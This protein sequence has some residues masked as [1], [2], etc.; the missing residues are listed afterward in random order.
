MVS[1]CHFFCLRFKNIA[2]S[3][4][5]E[6]Y[7][8]QTYVHVDSRTHN[9]TTVSLYPAVS[10]N[11]ALRYLIF[12][13]HIRCLMKLTTFNVFSYIIFHSWAYSQIFLPSLVITFVK[14]HGWE[15][16]WSGSRRGGGNVQAGKS[17]SGKCPVLLKFVSE[18]LSK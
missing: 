14:T 15:N 4:R 5:E 6:I 11:H 1:F 9:K 18:T 16:I 10:F 2:S 8:L 13:I 7:I 12:L 17:P 3:S